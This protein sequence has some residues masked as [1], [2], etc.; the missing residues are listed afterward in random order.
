MKK[1]RKPPRTGTSGPRLLLPVLLVALVLV[2]IIART[3]LRGGGPNDSEQ[4]LPPKP[5]LSPSEWNI[6]VVS[7]DT[8]R[9]DR[10]KACG[11]GPVATPNLNRLRGNGF[12]FT[13]MIAPA[14]ITLPSHASLFTGQNPY[15][16]GLRENTEFL[17]PS[18]TPTIASVFRDSGYRTAAFISSFTLHSRFGIDQGFELYSD[19]LSGPE[20]GLK[21]YQVDIPGGILVNRA[22]SWINDYAS[23]RATGREKKPF[24]AFVHFFDAHAPYRPPTP[25]NTA[26]DHPYHGELAYQDACLGKLLDTLE[27]TGEASR[28]LIWVVSDHGESLGEHAEAT[29]M[30]FIYDCTQRIVSVMKLPPAKG[31]YE[32]G[33]PRM[34]IDVQTGLIDVAPT[35]IN[36]CDLKST[37]PAMDGISLVPMM[38]G[39]KAIRRLIY[40]ETLSPQFSYHWSPLYG[41]RS[42][43]WKYIKAP[44][45]ELYNLKHDPDEKKNLIYKKP[46][47]ATKMAQMLERFLVDDPGLR[48]DSRSN[49]DDENLERLRSLGYLSGGE[50]SRQPEGD[51]PDPKEMITFFRNTFQPAQNLL[52]EGKH[53]EAIIELKK[54]LQADPNN[55][56]LL[57]NLATVYRFTGRL[58]EASRA[59]ARSLKIEPH[60][61]R[62]WSGWGDTLLKSAQYDS[63]AWAYGN[64]IDILPTSPEPW[65][66]LADL[67]WLQ[68][69]P[70]TAAALY[71][72]SLAKGGN[73]ARI[74]GLLA[75][76]YRDELNDP[77]RS[78]QHL[79]WFGQLT[80]LT[81]EAAASRLPTVK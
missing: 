6:L 33:A 75:R 2:A 57:Q 43:E 63:A 15:K 54:A 29:H 36:L 16:H 80:N 27:A 22:C 10:L 72:S 31:R 4:P 73:K 28:T 8:T 30:I 39:E 17:L 76:L 38:K 26:Y 49:L 64:A 74:H 7:L 48:D 14:P 81:P 25:Y 55:N 41:V 11:G 18:G 23:A 46:E 77:Q 59:Y 35:L 71:D 58:D 24:F 21:P 50:S 56:T 1:S 5:T 20:A 60:S 32:P 65:M 53:E 79:N 45:P 13:E 44:Q 62:T 52:F 40:C 68:G 12:L 19:D 78:Q 70:Q 69:E 9:P 61:S 66:G 47:M 34:T 37:L 3:I 51:L 67:R 42:E